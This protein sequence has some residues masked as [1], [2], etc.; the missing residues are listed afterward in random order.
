MK[1]LIKEQRPHVEMVMRLL[2]FTPDTAHKKAQTRGRAGGITYIFMLL[3]QFKS[4]I[5]QIPHET[6]SISSIPISQM[7]K[8]KLRKIDL[9]TVIQLI[10][11]RDM[12]SAWFCFWV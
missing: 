12:T 4:I 10:R 1:I 8:R 7:M 5:S 9:P 6:G 2:D 11:N 3:N